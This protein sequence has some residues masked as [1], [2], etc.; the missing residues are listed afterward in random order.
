MGMGGLIGIGLTALLL[1]KQQ[2]ALL[3]RIKTLRT[4]MPTA[5]AVMRMKSFESTLNLRFTEQKLE[6][7]PLT[8]PDNF[9]KWLDEN[10]ETSDGKPAGND[11]FG[12]RYQGDPDIDGYLGVRCCGKDQE[13]HSADDAVMKVFKAE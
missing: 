4:G 2:D 1:Y 3:E 8:L 7:N 11:P 5:E 10:F 12:G 13:C 9:P 6:G